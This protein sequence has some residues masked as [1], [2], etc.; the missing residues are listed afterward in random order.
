MADYIQAD[1]FAISVQ[2][3]AGDT[4]L[5]TEDRAAIERH[6]N[7]ASNLH[8]E[9]LTL[10]GNDAAEALVEFARMHQVAQIFVA[11]SAGTSRLQLFFGKDLVQQVVRLGRDMQV[12]V[13]ADRHRNPLGKRD[14]GWARG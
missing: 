8:I 13:V 3:E 7:F 12:T 4:H 1:C 6:M 11:R 5:S 9:T 2:P 10:K 14:K